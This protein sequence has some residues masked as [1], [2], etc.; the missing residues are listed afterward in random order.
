M[1]EKIFLKNVRLFFSILALSIWASVTFAG[2]GNGWGLLVDIGQLKV[3]N[4]N[5][6]TEYQESKVIGD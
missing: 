5:T 3:V 6:G 2:P 1:M 4:E